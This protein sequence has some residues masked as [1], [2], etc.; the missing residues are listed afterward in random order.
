MGEQYLI[1][2]EANNIPD[3]INAENSEAYKIPD[4]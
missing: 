4:I 1:K 2:S 3:N